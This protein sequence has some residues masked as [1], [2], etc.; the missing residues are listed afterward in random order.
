MNKINWGIIGCGDVTEIKSGPAFNKVPHSSLIAV[1]RR[2][3]EKAK[4]YAQRHCVSKWYNDAKKLIDDPEINAIYVATPPQSH[5]EYTL[6]ALEAGK[7]VYVEKPMAMDTRECLE[8]AEAAERLNV[9]L[10]IAHYRRGLPM[11]LKVKELLG[12]KSIGDIRVVNLKLFQAHT[13]N[14]IAKTETNWRVDPAISGGG[15]F[16]DLAPHQLDLMQF[17]FGKVKKAHGFALNQASLYAADDIVSGQVLYENNVIFNGIWCFTTSENEVLDQ[18]E[19]IGSA[20]KIVFAVFGN[21]I[22]LIKN[23]KEEQFYPE[24][25]NHVQQ[26]MIEKVVKYFLGQGPNPCTA[27]EAVETMQVMDKIVSAHN[28][29]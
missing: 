20:G 13:K 5:K 3:A 24:F 8:M 23:G 11:F 17:Y 26:P 16:H 22:S 21:T 18:C 10:T 9:K 27:R 6:M 14:L 29:L 25:P 19:I 12:Q 7:P 15:L 4:D 28:L 1:M 2:N